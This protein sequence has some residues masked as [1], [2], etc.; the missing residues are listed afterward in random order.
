[1]HELATTAQRLLDELSD[2]F[3]VAGQQIYL[4]TAF[5]VSCCPQD[6][7]NAHALLGNA[8]AAM[9]VAKTRGRNCCYFSVPGQ[10]AVAINTL[11]SKNPLR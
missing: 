9:R 4:T 3:P 5:G 1:M 10:D 6:G 8:E 11:T 7:E 2:P